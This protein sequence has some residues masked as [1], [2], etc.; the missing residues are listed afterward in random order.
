MRRQVAFSVQARR[1]GIMAY[2]RLDGVSLKLPFYDG[3]MLWLIRLSSYRRAEVGSTAVSYENIRLVVQLY[4]WPKGSIY[5]AGTAAR[6]AYAM[7]TQQAP[8]ALLIDEDIGAGDARF[9]AKAAEARTRN[10]FGRAK[11]VLLAS[12][13]PELCQAIRT[14]ALHFLDGRLVFLGDIDRAFNRHTNMRWGAAA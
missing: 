7:A 8:D 3:A 9:Q 4:K 11:V 1:W 12:L 5:S 10:F 6:L 13:A 2:I 14:R